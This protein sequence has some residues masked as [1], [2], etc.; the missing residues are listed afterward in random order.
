MHKE[1]QIPIDFEKSVAP[2]IGKTAKLMSIFIKDAFAEH[3]VDLTKEQFILLKVLHE[4]DG[5]I[6]KD[7]AFITER[8]KGSLARLINTMEKKNF[9]AR[10]PDTE[11]KRINRIHLTAHGHKIFLKTQPVVK[12]CMQKVQQGLTDEEIKTTISVLAKIQKNLT[13]QD[14]VAV[15]TKC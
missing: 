8:N 7:L 13:A 11:D 3:A 14:L 9:V 12:V 2:W 10:I 4:Q 6:Q 5:V 15:K 1:F